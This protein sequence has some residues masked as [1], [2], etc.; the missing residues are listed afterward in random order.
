MRRREDG[1]FEAILDPERINR[2]ELRIKTRTWLLARMLPKTFGDRP[3]P[4]ARQPADSDYDRDLAEM[5][6]L[7]D[8]R[9]RGL[10]G[11]D[12]PPDEE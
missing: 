8:G 10:P 1:S 3:V 2:A 6:K 11:E 5:I 4:S 12:E 9:T 7:I